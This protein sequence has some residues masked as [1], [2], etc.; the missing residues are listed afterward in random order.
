[1]IFNILANM[2]IIHGTDFWHLIVRKHTHPQSGKNSNY[3]DK[4][5]SYFGINRQKR[6]KIVFN[7]SI[8]AKPIDTNYSKT[9]W[10]MTPIHKE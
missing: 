9:I 2:F 8:F 7:N 3:K 1:M 4:G 5:M 10:K 6:I